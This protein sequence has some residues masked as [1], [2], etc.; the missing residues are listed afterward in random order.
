[1][2]SPREQFVRQAMDTEKARVNIFNAP[3]V[4][5]VDAS[6]DFVGHIIAN[7][8]TSLLLYGDL[9]SEA[10]KAGHENYRIWYEKLVAAY[11][12]NEDVMAYDV[13]NATKQL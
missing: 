10:E 3:G 2:E 4:T 12:F 6:R 1:M 9:I 5:G 8:Y 13:K 11:G 7:R